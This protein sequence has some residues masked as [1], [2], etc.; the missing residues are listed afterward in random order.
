[1]VPYLNG[2]GDIPRGLPFVDLLPAAA[3]LTAGRRVVIEAAVVHAER[4]RRPL[5][6]RPV[7]AAASVAFFHTAV[8][9]QL[10]VARGP[11]RVRVWPAAGRLQ[12]APFG[13]LIRRAAV[14][15]R[16]LIASAPTFGYGLH[17]RAIL[18]HVRL[19][20]GPQHVRGSAK[21]RH[22]EPAKIGHRPFNPGAV[23][24]RGDGG[25][26]PLFPERLPLRLAARSDAADQT[27]G[28]VVRS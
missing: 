11:E 18:G 1:M 15:S 7:A 23:L 17:A 27:A 3:E 28:L 16:R 21:R 12:P 20:G 19:N 4:L 13:S 25:Q 8:R 6:R 26:V 10:R 14:R 5:D 24:T 9:R 2:V 22:V